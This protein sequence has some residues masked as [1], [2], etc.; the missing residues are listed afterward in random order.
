MRTVRL[1]SRIHGYRYNLIPDREFIEV[2]PYWFREK[3]AEHIQPLTDLARLEI[4]HRILNSGAGLAIWIDADVLVLQPE[5]LMLPEVDDCAFT[6]EIWYTAENVAGYNAIERVNN[7]ISMFK[8]D[9]VFLPYYRYVCQA[10]A[11]SRPGQLAKTQIGTRL[12]TGIHA[13]APFTLVHNVGNLSPYVLH[14]LI[15]NKIEAISEYRELLGEPLYAANLSASHEDRSY[16]ANRNSTESYQ[17][18]V[19]ILLSP[20]GRE[21]LG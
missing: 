21:L 16:F 13:Y 18:A 19:R 2:A 12:L 20:Q 5:E 7:C 6:R 4:A 3:C 11:E 15:D 8:Q 9:G 14:C 17:R 10:I 1:W